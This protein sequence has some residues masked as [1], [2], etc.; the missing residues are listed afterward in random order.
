MPSAWC[1]IWPYSRFYIV[2]RSLPSRLRWQH[3]TP[4]RRSLVSQ[5]LRSICA[6]SS[7]VCSVS[8]CSD[9]A[10][11]F[12]IASIV[13]AFFG[14]IYRSLQR[15]QSHT[16]YAS[17]R[18]DHLNHLTRSERAR[19]FSSVTSV[20]LCVGVCVCCVASINT[21]GLGIEVACAQSSGRTL[22]PATGENPCVP[23]VSSLNALERGSATRRARPPPP[24]AQDTRRLFSG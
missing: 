5:F 7:G 22:F 24:P 1:A 11:P 15:V 21:T 14:F 16:G 17:R 9:V 19:S 20:V 4:R 8:L 13:N 2:I 3:H 12:A 10:R 23:T 18:T 6:M